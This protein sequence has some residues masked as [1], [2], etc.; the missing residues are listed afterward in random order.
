MKAPKWYPHHQSPLYA[1]TSKRR[2]ADVLGVSLKDLVFLA[3]LADHNYQVWPL[4]QKRRDVIAG[5]KPPVKP[6]NV[7]QPM[8]LLRTLHD[9]I[10]AF[11]GKIEKPTFVFSAT[12]GRSYLDNALQHREN[13]DQPA[14]KVDIRSFYP[15][16][17]TQW[18]RRF[19][20][21]DMK[22]APDVARFL[23]RLCCVNGALPT[24]SPI[25]PNLSYFACAPI[26]RWMEAFASARDLVFTLYVDD[27][28]FSGPNASRDMSKIVLGHLSSN[29]FR[30]H[31]VAHFREG[32]P[33]VITGSA[34]SKNGVS[35]PFKRQM[36]IRL[37][38]RAFA[39]TSDPEE[40]QILGKALLGQYREGERLQR[41]S[42]ERA[43]PIQDRMNAVN[44]LRFEELTQVQLKRKTQPKR[45]RPGRPSA[46]L[47]QNQIQKL[48][49]QRSGQLSV[50]RAPPAVVGNG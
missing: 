40:L 4:R 45:K 42:R 20:E 15:S 5:I 30:G 26:F 39:A 9:R 12:K 7:Q 19:F 36:R 34:I 14:F 23:A 41:G 16:V 47:I 27:M 10:A 25:S 21:H 49:E 35:I 6:R 38:E 32:Q 31:K 28:V 46:G 18:V 1:L 2:L 22:C 43:K 44:V 24:G 8:P 48:R 50:V 13:V 29:G 17:K 11:L 33:R 37:Y 3:S